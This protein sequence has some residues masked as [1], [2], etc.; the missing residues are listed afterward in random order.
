MKL[1]LGLGFRSARS[2]ATLSSAV[3]ITMPSG[4]SWAPSFTIYQN[5]SVFTTDFDP[6]TKMITGLTYYVDPEIGSDSSNDGLSSET[7]FAT[8]GKAVSMSGVKVIMLKAGLYKRGAYTGNQT[9]Q[10]DTSII[11]YGGGKALLSVGEGGLSWTKTAGQTN[12]Y[13]VTLNSVYAVIDMTHLQAVDA[14]PILASNQGSIAAV[15]SNAHS[16]YVDGSNILYVHTHDGRA[17]NADIVPLRTI[18]NMRINQN[19]DFYFENIEFWGAARP[20]NCIVSG[21]TKSITLNQC[22][23]RYAASNSGW[24]IDGVAECYLIDCETSDSAKDGID[25]DVLGGVAPKS[26]EVNMQSRRNGDST[27]NNFNGSTAHSG[28]VVIRL[29]GLYESNKGPQIADANSGSQSFNI[30]CTA[31]D[32]AHSVSA[33][34][35][36]AGFWV[37]DSAQ[38]WI[39]N[40]TASGCTYD[41]SNEGGTLTDLGGFSGGSG[42]DYGTIS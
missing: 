18:N 30:N 33:D 3:E 1:G 8:F 9:F 2:V 25:Y 17:P 31:K 40:G 22:A 15:D 4:F 23:S 35:G 37:S 11:A 21:G 39:L 38:M 6:A 16:W 41:R 26:L 13:Q 5:G 36:N 10:G 19:Y 14:A 34:S 42:S 24:T 12:V 7:P 27:A 20:F 32:S 28:A 29:N